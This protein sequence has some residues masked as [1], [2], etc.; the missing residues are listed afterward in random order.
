VLADGRL[1]V[2]I[3][4]RDIIVVDTPEALLVCSAERSQ[5]V[6][7]VVEELAQAAQSGPTSGPTKEES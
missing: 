5:D 1:V 2:T 6:R 7:R 4:L 3:G